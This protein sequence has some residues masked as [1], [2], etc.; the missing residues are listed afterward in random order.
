MYA[1]F[2]NCASFNW[3]CAILSWLD[4]SSDGVKA[5]R[6]ATLFGLNLCGTKDAERKRR[7]FLGCAEGGSNPFNRRY[8]DKVA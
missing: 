5:P 6:L 8:T 4:A 3:N 1:Q 2:F 7:Y